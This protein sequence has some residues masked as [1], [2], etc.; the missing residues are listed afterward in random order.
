MDF[1][2][3]K[4][5]YITTN[6]YEKLSEKEKEKF[7][8]QLNKLNFDFILNSILNNTQGNISPISVLK[9]DEIEKNKE[10]YY[11]V[12]INALKDG[13]VAMVSL[14]GGM[15]TR[16]GSNSPKGTYNVGITKDLYIFE[17]QITQLLNI[18]KECGNW[19][20]LFIMT[21]EKNHDETIEFLK[22]K[23]YFGYNEKYIV[24]FNQEMSPTTDFEGNV[25]MENNYTISTSPNGNGGWYSSMIKEGLMDIINQ[26]GIEY[27]NVY[28]IDNVLQKMADPYF[29][30]ATI[31][32][33]V[34]CG[35][36]VIKKAYPDEK[37][38]VI[39]LENNHPSI[40][41]Y[42]ELTDELRNSKDE[43]GNYKYDY[44]V[45]LNYLFKKS[46]LDKIASVG[47]PVHK[48]AK[49]IPYIND[50]G[51]LIEPSEPNGY[52]YETLILDMIKLLDTCLPYEVIREKEFAP[53]KN[54]HGVD[55]VDTARELLIKNGIKL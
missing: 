28:S 17:C 47:F 49:K 8:K 46:S 54:L 36:K 20:Y 7:H 19:I 13:K 9:T 34:D 41:E 4:S 37:L 24:F 51:D 23:N 5:K 11:K 26:N 39:C 1:T 43:Y 32:S 27:L 18:V 10:S 6:S 53:I 42:Y 52:K 29:I 31:L 22:S 14:A 35:A 55:S 40:T 38:G 16:L 2:K 30:G 48:V 21:S 33:N 50:K 44:G 45:I 3:L 12:G 25:L 15:G